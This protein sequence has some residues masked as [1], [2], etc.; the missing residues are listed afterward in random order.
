[1]ALGVERD[2]QAVGII[3]PRVVQEFVTDAQDAAIFAERHLGIM[4]LPSL[5]GGGEE[6][7]PPVLDPFDGL[8]QPERGPG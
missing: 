8:S 1:M 3:G 7:L 5:L 6:I 4:H 2:G